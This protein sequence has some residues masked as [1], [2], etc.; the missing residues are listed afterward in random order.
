LVALE[1]ER[2]SVP[3]CF[4]FAKDLQKQARKQKKEASEERSQL[5]QE[6]L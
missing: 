3:Y 4:L 2:M 5:V 6:Y 1:L